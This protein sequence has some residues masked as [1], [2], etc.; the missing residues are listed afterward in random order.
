[1]FESS[2]IAELQAWREV[3]T[4]ALDLLLRQT[5]RRMHAD[6]K[7]VFASHN[8]GALLILEAEQEKVRDLQEQL[9]SLRRN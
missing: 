1:M 6:S 3:V 9:H 5:D 4:N 2:E 7:A 8:T